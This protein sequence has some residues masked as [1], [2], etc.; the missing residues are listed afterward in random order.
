M[1][2]HGQNNMANI[3]SEGAG[4]LT[5]P[6]NEQDHIIAPKTASNIENINVLTVSG[7]I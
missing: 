2:A 3:E 4:K 7:L 5:L 6:V 1:H